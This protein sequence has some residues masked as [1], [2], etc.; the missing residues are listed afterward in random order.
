MEKYNQSIARG[1][2]KKV[3]GWKILRSYTK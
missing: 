2:P 3:S 1:E